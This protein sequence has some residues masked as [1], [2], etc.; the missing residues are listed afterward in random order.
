MTIIG[1]SVGA[2]LFRPAV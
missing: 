1:N 2:D